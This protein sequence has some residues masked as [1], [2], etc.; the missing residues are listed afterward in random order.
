MDQNSG[1]DGRFFY[2][3][4]SVSDSAKNRNFTAACFLSLSLSLSPPTPSTNRT[5]NRQATGPINE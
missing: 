3:I 4:A 1:N 5:Q 2:R